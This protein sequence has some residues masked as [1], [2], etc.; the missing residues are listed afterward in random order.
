MPK[1]KLW[2]LVLLN[3]RLLLKVD[4]EVKHSYG[5]VLD[6]R[7]VKDKPDHIKVWN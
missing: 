4:D 1:A 6:V 2:C 5:P 3:E 7:P